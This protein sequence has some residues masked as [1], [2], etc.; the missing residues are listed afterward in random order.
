MESDGAIIGGKE[1]QPMEGY[2][3]VGVYAMPPDKMPK[4]DNGWTDMHFVRENS[5]GTWSHK[6][7]SNPVTN[8]DKD[9]KPILD[10]KTANLGV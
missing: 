4:G 9:N 6:P 1:A 3:R 2:Y 10:P 7:G 5:D 8:R